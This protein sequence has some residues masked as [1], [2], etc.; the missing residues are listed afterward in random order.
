MVSGEQKNTFKVH[1]LNYNFL[2]TERSSKAAK[3][4]REP[5]E[6]HKV[7][8][9]EKLIDIKFDFDEKFFCFKIVFGRF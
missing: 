5:T 2:I 8:L 4:L 3:D 1:N 7:I 9:K 6:P